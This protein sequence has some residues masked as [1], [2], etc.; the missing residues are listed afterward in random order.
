MSRKGALPYTQ[1]PI[2]LK[3]AFGGL[4]KVLKQLVEAATAGWTDRVGQEA[5]SIRDVLIGRLVAD[6]EELDQQR[7]A[8]FIK[9]RE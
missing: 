7:A 1:S 8:S 3:K 5:Q 2:A 9:P 6:S 4:F